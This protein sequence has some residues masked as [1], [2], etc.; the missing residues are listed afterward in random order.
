MWDLK[1]FKDI[2]N[3]ALP[4]VPGPGW[5]HAIH[6]CLRGKQEEFAGLF[7]LITVKVWTWPER[8]I[9]PSH[10]LAKGGGGDCL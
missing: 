9:S 8:V 4:I 1:K 7:F 5:V 6:P 3:S 10:G 2:Q